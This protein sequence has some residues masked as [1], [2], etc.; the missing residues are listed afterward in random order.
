MMAC[1]GR[2]SVGRRHLKEL[3]GRLLA[4]PPQPPWTSLSRSTASR[5]PCHRRA[6]VLVQNVSI[7]TSQPTL[8]RT[9]TADHKSMA[10]ALT[11]ATVTAICLLLLCAAT[12]RMTI[13]RGAS[14]TTRCLPLSTRCCLPGLKHLDIRL[15]PPIECEAANAVGS[16]PASCFWI[17]MVVRCTIVVSTA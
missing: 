12:Y 17:I 13:F 9:R 16:E 2:S 14:S 4:D 10:A 11:R 8:A 1:K 3:S 7:M 6:I 15:Q 5:T